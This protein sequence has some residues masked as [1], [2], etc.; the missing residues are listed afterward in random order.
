[1]RSIIM[2]GLLLFSFSA[3]AQNDFPKNWEGNWKGELTWYK[4]GTKEPQKVSMELKIHPGDSA[5]TWSWQM[6]YG[7]AGEDSR[8]YKLI[9]KDSAGIHWVI[10]ELNG[11]VLDQYWVG[12]RFSGAFTVMGNTIINSYWIEEG[13]LMIEFFS[14]AAKPIATTGNGTEQSPNVDSY[15]LGSYQKAVLKRM[16]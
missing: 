7:A 5:N 1:M 4:T 15:R 6:V 13:K 16:E 10:D 3:I 8:P 9:R 12:N 11:I 2:T 14:M